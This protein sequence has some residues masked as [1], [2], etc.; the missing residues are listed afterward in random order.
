MSFMKPQVYKGEYFEVNTSAGTEI[1][2]TD[3]VGRT[4]AV[5]VDALLNYLE[6][7]PDDP[8]EVCE[9]HSGWLAR[10]SAP[11]YLDCTDWSAHRTET[12][13]TEYLN[14]MYGDDEGDEDEDE[15]GDEE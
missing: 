10:M 13:A 5:H 4:M 2:P 15:D 6:G 3:Y 14:E 1:V 8:E 12:E 7:T 11:D 9:V